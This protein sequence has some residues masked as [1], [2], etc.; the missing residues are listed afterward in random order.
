MNSILIVD[1]EKDIL[2]SLR[3]VLETDFHVLTSFTAEEAL[4]ILNRNQ[5][6]VIL[7]DYRLPGIL[8]TEFLKIVRERHPE[9]IR[10]ILTGYAET[11]VVMHAINSGHVYK[12]F[13][14]PC[15]PDL[16]KEELRDACQFYEGIQN[17]AKMTQRLQDRTSNLEKIIRDCTTELMTSQKRYQ[18]L[19]E[20]LPDWIWELD[21]NFRFT[22]CSQQSFPILGYEP[23]ELE[24]RKP[25]EFFINSAEAK[26]FRQLF[27]KALLNNIPIFSFNHQIRDKSGTIKFLETNVRLIQREDGTHLNCIGVSRDV[28]EQKRQSEVICQHEKELSL[29]L[30]ASNYITTLHDQDQLMQS[31]LL[32]ATRAVHADSGCLTLY[33][34]NEKYFSIVA[35]VGFSRSVFNR[36]KQEFLNTHCGDQHGIIGVVAQTQSILY[37]SNVQNDVRWIPVDS[38]IRSAMWIPVVYENKLTGML[39]LFSHE[40]D[41]FSKTSIRLG[42]LFANKVAVVLE[43]SNLYKKIQESEERYRLLIENAKD[44]VIQVDLSGRFT[45][46]NSRFTELSGFSAA[47]ATQL[48]YHQLIHPEDQ[49]SLSKALETRLAG[50]TVPTNYEFRVFDRSGNIHYVDATFTPILEHS[51][52]TGFQG[53]IRDISEKKYV[54]AEIQEYEEK[55]RVILEN[56]TEVVYALDSNRVITFISPTIEKVHNIPVSMLL[57]KDLFDAF[58]PFMNGCKN[59]PL[60]L[61]RFKQAIRT[62]DINFKFEF[63]FSVGSINRIMEFNEYIQYRQNG[64]I[65]AASGVIHDITERKRAEEHLIQTL[66][67]V[68]EAISLMIEHRDPYTAG[69][70][71]NTAKLSMAIAELMKLDKKQIEAIELAAFF[72]DVGKIGIPAEILNKSSLLSEAEMSIIQTHP[73]I[74]ASILRKIPRFQQIANFVEEHHERIDGSGYPKHLKKEEICLESRILAVADTVDAM[75]NHRPYRAAIHIDQV[76]NELLLSHVKKFDP[77][78]IKAVHSLYRDNFFKYLSEPAFP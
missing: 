29:L 9:I 24:H 75:I 64:E 14:K 17:K 43:N 22:F 27:Q 13:T 18:A 53:I 45:F 48:N 55:L 70:Q 31:I 15:N 57:G 59:I 69:H 65:L 34:E 38:T 73:S 56:L 39:N 2:W 44:M 71:R 49:R 60:I 4:K 61:K 7:A 74:G 32:G 78:V 76:M 62:K 67:G 77:N 36:I 72:L 66:S 1:D 10:M 51:N 3:Q 19:L 30:E 37:I 42:K 40:V 58:T 54:E 23:A 25:F 52:I 21:E 50:G 33:H 35:H 16:I 41:G 28:T 20:S 5:I 6:Q 12:L 46:V 8:G 47:E 63:E 68:K 11:D 26:Q